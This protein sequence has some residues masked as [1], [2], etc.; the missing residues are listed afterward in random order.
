MTKFLSISLL[1]CVIISCDTAK[2]KL[3]NDFGQIQKELTD[4]LN[5][6]SETTL[7]NGFGIVIVSDKGVLYQNG[8]GYANVATKEKYTDNTLQNIGSIS[9][10]FIGIALLKAQELGKLKLDDPINMY[11]PFSVINPYNPQTSITIRQLAT[12]TSSITDT[13]DYLYRAWIL[14]D[15]LNLVNNLKIDIGECKFSAPSTAIPMEE[16][17]KNILE[18]DGKWYKKENFLNRKPGELF[19]YSNLGATL[20]ALVIE[21]ATG[22]AFDKFTDKYILQPL[23]MNASGWNIDEIDISKHTRLYLNKTTSYPFYTL[24]TYP[25]GS[26]I[27]STSDFSKYMEELIQG[28]IGNG[29]LLSKESYKEY[30]SG[31]LKSENYIDRKKK[32]GEYSDE[33]NIGITIGISSTGNFGHTGGDPGLFSIMF[34]NPKNK[35]GKYIIVN[36]DMEGNKAWEQHY[37]IWSLLDIYADKLNNISPE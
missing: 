30:Y 29:I 15:T 10:T 23:G 26:M 4:T 34:F 20:A 19:Q 25:D 11:L 7:F 2:N 33:Y 17:L 1:I 13:R 22:I 32:E 6:I 37:K 8:F 31:Q 21:K 3:S 27:T 12:H 18:K 24:I 14:H 36:T 16:F 35:I 5:K 9:K 28:Y